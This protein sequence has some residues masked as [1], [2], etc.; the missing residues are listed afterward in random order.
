MDPLVETIAALSAADRRERGRTDLYGALAPVYDFVTARRIEYDAVAGFVER[1]APAEPSRTAVGACGG[2]HLL[3]RLAERHPEVVGIDRSRAMLALA[4]G[5]TDAPLV[6]ADLGQFVAPGA[7]DCYTLLGG[8]LAHLSLDAGGGTTD[9]D[10]VFENAY[11]S[12][13]PGGT[14]LCDF[15]EPGTIEDGSVTRDTWESD[16]VRVERTVVTTRVNAATGASC[17]PARYTHA[18]ELTD[19]E[20]DESVTAGTSAVLRE[21]RTGA[22]LGAAMAAGFDEV[23]VRT[24]PTHGAALV[25]RRIE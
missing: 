18:Y 6:R 19:T 5:R 16:R 13:A 8:T 21:F 24:P 11:E 23:T 22:L 17:R 15:M 4:A 14:F 7:F 9:V 20:T 12:L 2:G 10:A 3:V 25:A 1:N